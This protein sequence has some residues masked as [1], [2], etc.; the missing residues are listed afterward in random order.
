MSRSFRFHVSPELPGEI[1]TSLLRKQKR[2]TKRE[3]F[4]LACDTASITDAGGTSPIES[5]RADPHILPVVLTKREADMIAFANP[6]RRPPI[7]LEAV[8]PWLPSHAFI[9][10]SKV[11]FERVEAIV[12]RYRRH[13]I[14]AAEF[15]DEKW[16]TVCN[17]VRRKN[18]LDTCFYLAWHL[19]IQDVFVLEEKREDRAVV[20]IDFNAMYSACMQH[21]F[22]KPSS[23]E[24]IA[25]NR[26][27]APGDEL[28]AGLYRCLLSNPST[29]FI[30]RHNPF[31]SFRS[32]RY[33]AASL[34]E[35]V[36][37]DLNE[38]ELEYY[39]RHFDT[40]HVT[41]AVVSDQQIIHPLAKEATRSFA[42]RRNFRD[43]GNK[44]LADREKFLSTLLSSCASRPSSSRSS[45]SSREQAFEFLRSEY[46]MMPASD[47]PEAAID[48]WLENRGRLSSFTDAT[49]TV[50]AGPD[51]SDQSTCFLFN[52][53]IVARGRVMVLEKM[54]A[55]CSRFPDALIC[56]SNIDSIH[57][58]FPR[59]DIESALRWL[60][61]KA[62][63][64]MGSFKIE[65]ITD[66]GLWLEPGR[67]WLYSQQIEK[68]RNRG[69]ST[70]GRPFKDHTIHVESR[71]I[72]DLHIPIK[73]G[74]AMQKTMSVSRSLVAGG[75]GVTYQ[76][77]LEVGD[78]TPF[79][80]VLA[81]LE[82]N[83]A[84]SVSAR[85]EAFAQLRDEIESH[86]PAASG[87]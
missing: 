85:A 5:Y 56:Y 79:E 55:I 77:L 3:F 44:A 52:Q 13:F 39:R 27:L 7:V 70:G 50:I 75:A 63:E 21:T 59:K 9:D 23:L 33:L 25:W 32:G 40:I 84:R 61:S 43:Q 68:F 41:H 35:S 67:Y 24:R 78:D 20:A 83:R 11:G 12:R 62:S 4:L 45:F 6:G 64:E 22:P 72:G 30:R 42:C 17:A 8:Y 65:A 26:A 69:I 60:G 29:D 80:T 14:S 73:I 34:D 82:D 46:G 47:E 74:V 36:E 71:K 87:Q 51:L 18:N 49:G 57:I 66:H 53:R 81:A 48:D 16:N 58:S 1:R 28:K 86:C 31:R 54:E 38:F 37:V 15:C 10:N 76:R 2:R 19:P